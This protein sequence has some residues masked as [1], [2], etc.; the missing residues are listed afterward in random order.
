MTLR[1]LTP[2]EQDDQESWA[3]RRFFT[4]TDN[5]ALSRYFTRLNK[6]AGTERTRVEALFKEATNAGYRPKLAVRLAL[7]L[8]RVKS[9]S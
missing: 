1:A 5:E 8:D 4:P 2:E 7:E 6:L 3:D 9:T